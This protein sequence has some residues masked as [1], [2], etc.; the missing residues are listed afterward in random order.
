MGD[1]AGK[2]VDWEARDISGIACIDP[3]G[4]TTLR[5]LVVNDEN[6]SAQF[7]TI[8]GRKIVVGSQ[9][10]LVGNEPDT[11]TVGVKPEV[12]CPGGK[13]EFGEFD[14]EGVAYSE[15]HFYVVGSHA[16][17][18]KKGKF[19][20]SSFLLARIPVNQDGRVVGNVQT[21][22]RLSDVLRQARE[23]GSYFGKGISANGV[24]VEG[25]SVVGDRL[26][27]GLRAPSQDGKA[28]LVTTSVAALF[29]PGHGTKKAPSK[30]IALPLG[31]PLGVRDLAMLP[32]GRLLVLT[33][34]AQEQNL[35]YG[36]LVVDAREGNPVE[37]W[38]I[39]PDELG[40]ISIEPDG[41]KAEAVTI[42][43]VSSDVLRVLVLFDGP[44]NGAPREYR[45]PL[46]R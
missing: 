43:D 16:C 10:R 36:F 18:R 30:V 17:S 37:F 39:K 24:N 33:G 44:R 9:I 29:A 31:K 21:T 40:T 25:L 5:C 3:P 26:M 38:T 15:G 12:S 27:V 20:L 28:Y 22:Y 6:H 41:G 8:S 7:V 2:K 19:R 45:V 11:A 1:L 42:L 13:G 23:V 34:P 14:G 46:K 35:P 32:D 4:S